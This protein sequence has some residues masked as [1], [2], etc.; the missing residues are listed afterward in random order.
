M[1]TYRRYIITSH[2]THSANVSTMRDCSRR[3]P[4]HVKLSEERMRRVRVSTGRRRA[5]W[6]SM[7]LLSVVQLLR[8]RRWR[9]GGRH[10]LGLVA[11]TV[12]YCLIVAAISVIYTTTGTYRNL[13]SRTTCSPTPA[14]AS[15]S[16]Y[17]F[18]E[19]NITQSL[20]SNEHTRK[21][22]RESVTH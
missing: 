9:H 16:S 8:G 7:V 11:D 10:Q 4:M 6:R 20:L 21:A 18:S 12:T 15:S 2:V 22:A 1:V 13:S 17:L 19:N 5:G 14:A 3:R